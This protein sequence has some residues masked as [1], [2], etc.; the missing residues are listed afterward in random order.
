M[1]KVFVVRLTDEER[2]ELITLVRKEKRRRLSSRV[3]EFC[4]KR[5]KAKRAKQRL[6]HKSRKP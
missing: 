6:M 4:S 5:T 2:L 3:P 1:K